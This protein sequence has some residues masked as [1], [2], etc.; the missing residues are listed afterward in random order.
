MELRPV[1]HFHV[2]HPNSDAGV[3]KRGKGA[4]VAVMI[5]PSRNR[6]QFLCFLAASPLVPRAWPQA[7]AV[8]G[9]ARDALDVMDFEPAARKVL[10]PAHWGYLATGVDDDATLKADRTAFQ[11]YQLKPRRLVDIS[12]TDLRTELFGTIW[13]TPIFLV[14]WAERARSIPKEK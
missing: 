13:E 5:P 1:Y 8:I 7:P 12:Q 6:R 11:H 9:S 10:R 3:R 4:M 14:R 2:V